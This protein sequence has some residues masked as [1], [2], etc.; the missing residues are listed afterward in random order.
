MTDEESCERNCRESVHATH[1]S[2]KLRELLSFCHHLM[3]NLTNM[4]EDAD[5]ATPDLIN[6]AL[7]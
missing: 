7:F 5:N 6:L 3:Q 2:G 1:L 4:A